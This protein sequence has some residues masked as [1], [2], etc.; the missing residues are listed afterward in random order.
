MTPARHPAARPGTKAPEC[1]RPGA[2]AIALDGAGKGF[3]DGRRYLPVLEDFDLVV[4]PGEVVA[5]RGPSGSGKSTLLNLIAGLL[6]VDRGSLTLWEGD[7]QHPM[8]NLAADARAA[9]RRRLVGYVFQFFNLV[10]TLT[11]LENVRLPLAL[12][13]RADLEPR[14][15]KRL[16]ALGL[17]DALCA[18]PESLSG[19]ERQRVAIARALAHEPAIV[20]ADE[21]TGNLDPRNTERIGDL[22]WSEVERLHCAMVVATHS[23]VIA[24]RADRIVELHG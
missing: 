20:L 9:V 23:E 10:P 14:A 3:S 21:P 12:N 19:G 11:V 17:G 7:T 1:G 22:L 6:T 4:A 13:R 5:I 8:H 2:P 16:E 18:F 24:R 15:R